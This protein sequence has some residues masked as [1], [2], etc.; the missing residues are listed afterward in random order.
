MSNASG[1]M[2]NVFD[3]SVT[4]TSVLQ[5]LKVNPLQP[6]S[7]DTNWNTIS[8]HSQETAKHFFLP[9]SDLHI[10]PTESNQL[11]GRDTLLMTI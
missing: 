8:I 7:N 10:W 6:V 1:D 2:A 4:L 11:F 3:F 5:S 9:I